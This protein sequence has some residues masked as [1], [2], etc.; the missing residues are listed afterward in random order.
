MSHLDEGTIHALLD[1]EVPSTELAPIQAHLERCEACKAKL[2]EERELLAVSDRLIGA[3]QLAPR[4][5]SAAVHPVRPSTRPP[6]HL[7]QLAWAA[8]VVLAAG[9]GYAMGGSMSA[10]PSAD[11]ALR[12]VEAALPVADSASRTGFAAGTAARSEVARDQRV[13]AP[14]AAPPERRAAAGTR[15]DE[16]TRDAGQDRLAA[17]RP[18]EKS[19]ALADSAGAQPKLQAET[20]SLR[21]QVVA[22]AANAPPPA[23][24][25]AP[26]AQSTSRTRALTGNIRLEEAV[27]TG[28]SGPAVPIEFIEAVRL[29]GGTLRLVEGLVPHRLEQQGTA[30]RVVYRTG[31]GELV[32][33]QELVDGRVRHT[34]IPPTGFPADS[35]G[36]L[37]VK[38]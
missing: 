18:E 28:V 8:T 29:M 27:V 15:A 12:E 3:V 4:T 11:M 20:S 36:K 16:A 6:V 32:L 17:S 9:L 14:P 38:E 1:G 31:F 10:R 13:A 37:R 35:L 23:A 33:S 5:E 2:A 21:Q 7:R 24:V 25:A 30:V 19:R 26:A 34:L 22:G